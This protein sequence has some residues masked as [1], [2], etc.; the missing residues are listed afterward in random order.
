MASQAE[1]NY[2][3]VK[4]EF[5]V[6]RWKVC[7]IKCYQ[8]SSDQTETEE[9]FTS[10]DKAIKFAN[11]L[12]RIDFREKYFGDTVS[13]PANV[14]IVEVG[15]YK[16]EVPWESWCE[17]SKSLDE[18]IKELD[19]Q[20]KYKVW[21]TTSCNWGFEDVAI[22]FDSFDKAKDAANK[23]YKENCCYAYALAKCGQL[24]TNIRI[25]FIGTTSR[26]LDTSEW[27]INTS[28]I[29]AD[30]DIPDKYK[31]EGMFFEVEHSRVPKAL[32]QHSEAF[33]MFVT[34]KFIRFDNARNFARC[35]DSRNP[36]NLYVKE[37]SKH[38]WFF[39]INIYA[40]ENGVRTLI[41]TDDWMD[42]RCPGTENLSDILEYCSEVAGIKGER[43]ILND[44]VKRLNSELE[45]SNAEIKRL[46]SIIDA[47]AKM[48]KSQMNVLKRAGLTED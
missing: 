4:G 41:P 33:P 13:I 18:T 40:V 8:C 30:K 10:L 20:P 11:D 38:Y 43:D 14:R 6:I 47:S 28:G 34:D 17:L 45:K 27:L 32:S 37:T 21:Y 3:E 36:E 39:N 15:K 26:F 2:R 1:Q 25:E 5:S 31:K 23:L 24:K 44:E 19:C 46:N 29:P 7:F 16:R 9:T 22:E 48:L 35:L 12:A 42:P